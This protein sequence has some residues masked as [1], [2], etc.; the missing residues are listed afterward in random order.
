MNEILLMIDHKENRRL[1]AETLKTKCRVIIPENDEALEGSF[2]LCILDGTAMERL[3]DKVRQ[4]KESEEPLF[5]P[6]LLLTT[7]D[8]ATL[9]TR[10]L[11]QFVDEVV[12]MPV[13]RGDLLAR[14]EVLYRARKHSE[15][16][17]KFYYA[18]SRNIPTSVFIVQDKKIVYANPLASSMKG[19]IKDFTGTD[20]FELFLPEFQEPLFHCY[21]EVMGGKIRHAT[22]MAAYKAGQMTRLADIRIVPINHRRRGAILAIA[23]DI[24]DHIKVE[25]DLL[26]LQDQL[27]SL[28]FHQDRVREEERTHIAREIHDEFGQVLTY[29]RIDLVW[30]KKNTPKFMYAI[31]EKIQLLIETVDKTIDSVTEIA[32]ELRPRILDDLGLLTAIEWQVGEFQKRYDIRVETSFKP[33]DMIISPFCSTVIFRIFQEALTNI[34]RHAKATL[35]KVRL[36]QKDGHV[37]MAVTDDGIGF[38]E[39]K[40][41]DPSSIGLIGIRERILFLGGTLKITSAIGK[42]TTILAR[43][44]NKE[45]EEYS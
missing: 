44:P 30:M 22:C 41:E 4:R 24:T 42:G 39:D 6:I 43:I 9:I 11:W 7:K 15:E 29:L 3:W 32:T 37:I 20:F 28:I 45:K 34:A 5:L 25:K 36:K 14:V 40:L 2:E 33:V 27:R 12:L 35:V 13:D 1:L 16:S 18:L 19:G 8:D 26:Q 10:N 31:S 21:N 17:A 38:D 23:N